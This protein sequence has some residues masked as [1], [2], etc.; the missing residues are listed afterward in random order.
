MGVISNTY[1]KGETRNF[2]VE[3]YDDVHLSA[4]KKLNEANYN[5]SNGIDEVTK[6]PSIQD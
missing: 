1:Y 2:K 4:H 6:N 5:D 3:D